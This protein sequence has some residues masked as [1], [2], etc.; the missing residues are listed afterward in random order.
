MQI[1]IELTERQPPVGQVSWPGHPTVH[2]QGW[3]GLLR[4]LSDA[5]T[6]PAPPS[7]DG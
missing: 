1:R 3:L 7:T 5:I 2:F 6:P 4:V